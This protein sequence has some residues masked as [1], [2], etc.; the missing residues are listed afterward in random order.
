MQRELSIG[1]L[2]RESGV[3]VPTIRYYESVDLLPAPVRT[4]SNRRMYCTRDVRRLSFIRHARELGFEVEAIRELLALADEP[5]RPCAKADAIAWAHLADIE[6]K[7]GRLELLRA[8]VK[9]MLCECARGR[10]RECRVIEVLGSHAECLGEHTLAV[11][12]QPK[13]GR[14]PRN[15]RRK[16]V[17]RS[18]GAP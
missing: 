17:R 9:R 7:I 5:Q 18:A 2:A 3:K 4:V 10:I 12:P 15:Q 11:R 13:S 14:P 6:S 8:E 16:A 1:N